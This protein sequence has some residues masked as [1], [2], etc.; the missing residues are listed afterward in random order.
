MGRD[1]RARRAVSTLND[2]PFWHK[3]DIS[4]A[5]P[6]HILRRRYSSTP[7]DSANAIKTPIAT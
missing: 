5:A 6:H 1:C 3:A 7:A 2:V 4:A